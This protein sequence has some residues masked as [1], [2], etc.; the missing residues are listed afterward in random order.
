MTR[1]II[2]NPKVRLSSAK[3]NLIVYN[4]ETKQQKEF[5]IEIIQ[6]IILF[7]NAQVTTQLIKKLANKG[8]SIH[9][10]SRYGKYITSTY[11]PHHQNF[12]KQKHQI[13]AVQ[14][15]EFK[16]QISRLII[17]NKIKFQR[18]LLK[19]YDEDRV[20]NN[21]DFGKFND[22]IEN[23]KSSEN[24]A[25]IMGYEG[26]AA[27]NYFYFLNFLVPDGFRFRGR[28]KRPPKDPFNA[29]IS[30]GYHI[31]YS[32]ISGTLSIHG[33][34]IGF[35][36]M[37]KVKQKHASLASDLIEEWRSF[38]VDEVVMRL[39]RSHRI[40]AE[41]FGT[42]DDTEAVFLEKDYHIIF[43]NELYARMNEAHQYF[44]E[45]NKR[46]NFYSALDHQIQSLNRAFKTQDPSKYKTLGLVR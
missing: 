46:Y 30:L 8:K 42:K 5:A 21:S 33:N 39:I 14:N 37:H 11:I 36:C 40:R 17:Q 41:M 28:K 45:E 20:L 4:L 44:R 22:Y 18:E 26:K 13:L 19:S 10:F 3:N 31:L 38:L 7:G 43:L 15:E 2:Q 9:Y 32:I 25:Q 6:H 16:L 29:L 23:V 12:M 24:I 35:G 27:K 34:L 1:L